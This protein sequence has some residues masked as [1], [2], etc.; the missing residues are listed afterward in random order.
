MASTSTADLIDS[1][2][3]RANMDL[4]SGTLT[5]TKQPENHDEKQAGHL[6]HSTASEN[7]KNSRAARQPEESDAPDV[8]IRLFSESVERVLLWPHPLAP[9][10]TDAKWVLPGPRDDRSSVASW[11]EVIHQA[12]DP[13]IAKDVLIIGDTGTDTVMDEDDL[14]K[15]PFWKRFIIPE[16]QMKDPTDHRYFSHS[17]RSAAFMFNYILSISQPASK[18][19]KPKPIPKTTISDVPTK[20]LIEPTAAGETSGTTSHPDDSKSPVNIAPKVDDL[21]QTP[22]GTVNF[23]ENRTKGSKFFLA[24]LEGVTKL[25]LSL[26]ASNKQQVNPIWTEWDGFLASCRVRTSSHYREYD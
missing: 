26:A 19:L 10:I 5:D 8:I 4:S 20:P 25:L 23:T 13:K 21:F 22:W 15:D 6:E 24:I 1:A 16:N 12:V 3:K 14:S 11:Q 17:I 9:Y 7:L 2:A 18:P